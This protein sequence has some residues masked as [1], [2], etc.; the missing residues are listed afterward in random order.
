VHAARKLGSDWKLAALAVHTVGDA[1]AKQQPTPTLTSM[2]KQEMTHR[3]LA[4][5]KSKG[6]T[7]EALADAVGLS[8]VF[9]TSGCL[10][11]NSIAKEFADKVVTVLDLDAEVSEALQE[12]PTKGLDA[13][14][15]P[16]DPLLYRFHE[17]NLVYGNTIKALIQ[18]KFGDGIMS[19]I[20]F[21]MEID[22]VEDPKG[23]RVKVT[24]CG[25]FLPYKSW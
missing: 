12:F 18:E 20:D 8:P 22:K 6:L 10:G 19:A 5:K 7:W 15:V 21:T 13:L 23:D 2:T 1:L 25:K 3:I 16:T 11:Q 14:A 9:V 17:I 24:M 4:S